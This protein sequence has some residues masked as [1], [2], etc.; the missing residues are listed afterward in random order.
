VVL[1]NGCS[2]ALDLVI[3][4]IAN[5]GQNILV[6]RPGFAL[7]EVLCG[8]KGIEARFYD[9]L[10]EKNWEAD[11][12]QLNELIDAN[13]AAILINNPSNP[14]GSVFSKDHLL[15]ILDVCKQH[16]V[17]LISDEIYCDMVF[18]SDAQ[19]YP[20]ASLSQEVPIFAVGGLAK[21]WLVPG[22]RIG[23]ILVHDY[24]GALDEVRTGLVSLS[25]VIHGPN[26]II[27]C[28]LP[29]ILQDTK[30]SFYQR[31]TGILKSNANL[32]AHLASS[33][34]GL[35]V[36]RPKGAM[37]MMIGIQ[38]D[39]FKDIDSDTEFCDKLLAEQSVA[40]LPGSVRLSPSILCV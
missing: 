8:S 20:A 11:L 12:T 34:P 15:G 10:P 7:Y 2:G 1:T 18:G 19:F 5:E 35:K 21:K 25:Q 22:W 9:L 31:V 17:P 33:I 23:W 38:V 28:A 6:P 14:C 29:R 37:Y 26:T 4:A 16:R 36:I 27:Q 3:T 13:T 30:A 40:T 24:I 32:C 39:R